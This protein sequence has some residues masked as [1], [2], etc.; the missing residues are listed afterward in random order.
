MRGRTGALDYSAYPP[1]SS[2]EE[3]R[4]PEGRGASSLLIDAT[5]KWPYPPTSLPKKEY[6]DGALKIWNELGLG[7]VKLKA[8]WY[9]YN[10]GCWTKEDEENAELIVS[11]K[12]REVGKKLLAKLG[13]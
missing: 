3:V 2:D 1:G 6:M 11:G 12:Y 10:L 13:S 5:L 4:Y 8:P 9:G 7:P